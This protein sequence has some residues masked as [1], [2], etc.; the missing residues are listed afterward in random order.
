LVLSTD[1]VQGC[2]G[3][4]TDPTDP[5]ARYCLCRVRP[6]CRYRSEVHDD[7]ERATESARPVRAGRAHDG[8][9]AA[10]NRGAGAA[11]RRDPGRALGRQ[12]HRP[13]I[14]HRA[15]SQPASANGLR[16]YDVLVLLD[17][18][19]TSAASVRG[20]TAGTIESTFAPVRTSALRLVITDS[21]D[22]GYSRVVELEAYAS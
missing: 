2:Y 20:N 11:G 3:V 22:H 5:Y 12:P 8:A 6:G 18:A 10:R 1:S 13:R 17:G 16:D 19:W 7:R 14:H 9:G 21:N 15:P 4:E